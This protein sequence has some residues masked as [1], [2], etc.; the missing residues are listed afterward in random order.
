MS[1]ACDRGKTSANA[2]TGNLPRP[3]MMSGL[4]GIWKGRYCGPMLGI[5]GT[6]FRGAKVRVRRPSS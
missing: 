4:I 3:N 1:Q 2:L 5:T 6:I